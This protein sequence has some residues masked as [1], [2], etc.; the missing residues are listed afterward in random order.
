MKA[1]FCAGLA[2]ALI[3]APARAEE[4]ITPRE[5]IALFNGKDLAGLHTWLKK[6]KHEDPDRVFT[7]A[8]GM[9][10]VSGADNGYV[11]TDRAYRDYHLVVEYRWGKN[12]FG[13][14]YVRNSGILLHQTGPDAVWPACI[15][16]QLAQG[17]AGDIIVI[18]GKDAK[19]EIIPVRV[20]AETELAPDQ[21]RHRWKKGGD[22]RTFPP[23]KGQLWWS[24]HDWNFKELIDTRGQDDVESPLGD[25]TKVECICAGKTITIRVNGQT[26]NEVGDVFPAAGRI[27]LQSEGFEMD[28]RRFELLPIKKN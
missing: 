5:T 16:C 1:Y 4:P 19:G 11:A 6:S 24:K 20:S 17:C 13:S 18:R 26:V 21:R 28:F 8:N 3:V 7:V 15:E 10:H 12:T 25:W 27:L 22:L 23:T 2:L 14:K 9:I